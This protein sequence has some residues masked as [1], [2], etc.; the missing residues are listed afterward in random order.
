[1]AVPACRARG[2]VGLCLVN[3]WELATPVRSRES[4]RDQSARRLHSAV[5][6]GLFDFDPPRSEQALQR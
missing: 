4:G 6:R 3:V 2:Q 5:S 1:V